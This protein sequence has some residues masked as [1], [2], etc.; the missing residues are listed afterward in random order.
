MT[1]TIAVVAATTAA[2]AT[3]AAAAAVA[4]AIL[5]IM[6]T[7]QTYVV[8]LANIKYNIDIGLKIS[9]RKCGDQ[10]CPLYGKL[11]CTS[12]R[13]DGLANCSTRINVKSVAYNT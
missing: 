1:T 3:A 4:V 9:T 12:L 8:K 7:I 2:A 13:E 10:K 6:I 11:K 5:N